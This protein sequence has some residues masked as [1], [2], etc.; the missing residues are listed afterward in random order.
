MKRRINKQIV[1]NSGYKASNEKNF[2]DYKVIPSNKITMDDVKSTILGIM[3]DGKGKPQGFEFMEPGNDYTFPDSEAIVEIPK[4]QSAGTFKG[5]T[6]DQFQEYINK[7]QG[8]SEGYFD[9]E[10][11]YPGG[12]TAVSNPPVATSPQPNFN[13]TVQNRNPDPN[14]TP[15]LGTNAPA[16]YNPWS[17]PDYATAENNKITE[18]AVDNMTPTG[19]VDGEQ[20]DQWSTDQPYQ[21][22]NPY[23]GVDMPTAA[24]TLGSSIQEGNALGIAGS[25]LK[26]T[27]GIARNAFSGAGLA[28]RQQSVLRGYKD[29]QRQY[30]T[31]ENRPQYMA[32]GG[33]IEQALTGEYMFG[34]NEINPMVQPN[35]EIET[36]EYVQHPT[37]EIQRAEGDTHEKGGM[38]V[39]LDPGTKIL[40]DHLKIGGD[41]AKHF[42]NKFDL[43]L[44]AT[45]TFA[46]VLDKFNHKSG[47]QKIVDEQEDLYKQLKKQQETTEDEA[48][49]GLNTQYLT[50]KLNELSDKKKPLEEARKV[51][52]NEIFDAQ[53]EAKPTEK[54]ND[55]EDDDTYAFGGEIKTLAEKY[56]IPEDKVQE[57]IKDLPKYQNGAY[58]PQQRK[59]RFK[60]F[61]NQAERLGYKGDAN[62]DA[63][64]LNSEAGKLQA[65]MVQNY[66][67]VITDY[68]KGVDITAKGV[69]ILK[70]NNPGIFTDLGLPL[71]KASASYTPEEKK[72]LVDA[73]S[74]QGAITDDF[75]KEQ[76]QDN[77][78]TY[79][80]PQ[81]P[82]GTPK[83]PSDSTPIAASVVGN[84]DNT[85]Q[86]TQ[87]TTEQPV[88]NSTEE[89]YRRMGAFLMPEQNPLPPTSLM[90]NLK[91]NRR[92]D[93]IDPALISSDQNLQEIRRQ[94]ASAT[95]QINNLPDSQRIAA[96]SNLSSNTQQNINK[97]V[98]ETNRIN[99]QIITNADLQNANTQKMEENAAASD[100]LSYEQRQYMGLAK[101]QNDY[102]NYYNTLTAN[103]VRNFNTINDLNLTNAMYDDYQ[104]TGNGI[105]RVTPDARFVNP[106][107]IPQTSTKTVEKKKTPKKKLG[108]RF[109]K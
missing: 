42:R 17:N 22:F 6:Y 53:E 95:D 43:D 7:L 82:L 49:L 90:P 81:V 24:V 46:R 62:P 32:K 65:W 50:G 14:F 36:G 79:R 96:L 75:Y 41:K 66:P 86:P 51:L 60:D 72:A 34:M 63:E 76:F 27:A 31:G 38:D 88:Q 21:F 106:L 19:A 71:N 10:N 84:L 70:K 87:Q 61:Y 85:Q 33:E 8:G 2:T 35:A 55:S 94:E 40:S 56:G 59:D 77:K 67:Q 64:D 68:A 13:P 109:K 69:D 78:W 52:F 18:G 12:N 44:K 28:K 1:D 99:S 89:D 93:R 20:N 107:T 54:E 103:N 97:V 23:G 3:L 4:Y 25:A 74:K 57:L 98:S 48:S 37:S 92:F 47:L 5:G 58:T 83:V 104:F 39:K 105:E 80:F 108:G 102:A 73:A 26:L 100:A 29:K 9:F 16:S 11:S 45:D 15:D 91:V 101:T 30:V